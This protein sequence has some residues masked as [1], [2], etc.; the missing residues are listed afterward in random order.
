M[1]KI[2]D[3]TLDNPTETIMPDSE[4][5]KAFVKL[6]GNMKDYDADKKVQDDNYER[7]RI[8]A[9]MTSPTW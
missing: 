1:S 2:K 9:Y 8:D 6:F 7:C 3:Y 4:E 5:V